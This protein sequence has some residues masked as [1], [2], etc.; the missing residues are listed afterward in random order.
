[1]HQKRRTRAERGR[2]LARLGSKKR[3]TRTG[4]RH[5]ASKTAHTNGEGLRTSPCR[6]QKKRIRARERI[7]IDKMHQKANPRLKMHLNSC[8]RVGESKTM[9]RNYAF[10]QESKLGAEEGNHD[11]FSDN[12]PML[13]FNPGR[14]AHPHGPHILDVGQPILVP[15]VVHLHL[16]M[17]EKRPNENGI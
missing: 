11:Q 10:T 2:E 13:S 17:N 7:S 15:L 3:R 12:L 14:R 4:Y 8:V 9:H 16:H 1:M 6:I 5:N